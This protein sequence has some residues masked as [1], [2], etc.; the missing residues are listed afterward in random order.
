LN[1]LNCIIS[2]ALDLK[3]IGTGEAD[4]PIISPAVFNER[5]TGKRYRSLPLQMLEEKSVP[6]L[7]H[8]NQRYGADGA[9][10]QSGAEI[11]SRDGDP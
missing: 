4:V 7:F 3:K 10:L 11:G 9:S 1:G 8:R 2:A 6:R 5:L